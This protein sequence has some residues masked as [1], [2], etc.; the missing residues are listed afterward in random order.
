L[1]KVNLRALREKSGLTQQQVSDRTN[2]SRSYYTS[3]ENDREECRF[4]PTVDV[5]KRIADTL[6]FMWEDYYKDDDA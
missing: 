5:V 6:S 3:L 2:I 1:K 4:T